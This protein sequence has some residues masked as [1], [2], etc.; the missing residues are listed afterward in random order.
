MLVDRV[1]GHLELRNIYLGQNQAFLRVI[2]LVN[3]SDVEKARKN[4]QSPASTHPYIQLPAPTPHSQT[5]H[6]DLLMQNTQLSDL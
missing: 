5:R 1:L 3:A 4:T 6:H 2:I